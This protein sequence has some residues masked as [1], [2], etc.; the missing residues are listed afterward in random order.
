MPCSAPDTS[1]FFQFTTSQ[2][3]RLHWRSLHSCVKI[4]Q[5]T[6]SQGGRQNILYCVPCR[7]TFNSR[8]H[9]EVDVMIV[10]LSHSLELSIHD[11]TRRSTKRMMK[12][13]PLYQLSIHDLTRR[14]TVESTEEAAGEELSIHDLTRRST[15]NT[16]KYREYLYKFFSILYTPPLFTY[17]YSSI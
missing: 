8:P 11:L 4:F 12:T 9:K 1:I 16:H 17:F 7:T 10:P 2:G 3:G 14:S 15:A 6:T 5:F 13:Y